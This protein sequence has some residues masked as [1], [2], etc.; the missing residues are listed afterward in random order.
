MRFGPPHNQLVN[1]STQQ[2]KN[3]GYHQQRNNEPP[4]D[5]ALRGA[6]EVIDSLR[7]TI[8][9]LRQSTAVPDKKLRTKRE[10]IIYL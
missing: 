8:E 10:N 2:S 6:Q 1:L 3:W 5:E 7:A 9:E 4:E